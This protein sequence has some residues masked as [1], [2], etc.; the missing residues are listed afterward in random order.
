V[1]TKKRVLGAEHPSTLI[2]MGNL[3][4]TFWN[5]RRWKEAEELGVQ[6]V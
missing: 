5:Q 2:S 1:E 3:T 4:S 6:V